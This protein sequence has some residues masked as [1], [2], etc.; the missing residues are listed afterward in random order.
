M[1]RQS[2]PAMII[3]DGA[4]STLLAYVARNPA[5]RSGLRGGLNRLLTYVSG[6]SGSQPNVTAPKRLPLT[7][8]GTESV[9][10]TAPVSRL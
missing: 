10:S 6:R 7:I 3:R 2:G 5:R 1:I 4:E 8:R 9:L